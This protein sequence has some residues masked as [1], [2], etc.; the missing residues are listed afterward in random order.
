MRTL[1]SLIAALALVAVVAGC[2]AVGCTDNQNSI[3]LAGFY[4][5]ATMKAIM[6]ESIAVA[7]VGAPNDSL[8]LG[9]SAHETQV[10]LPLRATETVT[11]FCIRYRQ[12]ALDY[13]QLYDTLTFSYTPVPYFASAD[14]GAMYHYRIRRL[15]YTRHLID[16]VGISDSTVTNVERETIQIYF[17][18]ATDDDADD[19]D[20]STDL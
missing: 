10:Y 9:P 16:S 5:M 15:D 11:Q 20:E 17:Y 12:K 18:T 19:A 6:P 3:P 7:G 4:D 8:L 1:L 14:C 13:P 2:N